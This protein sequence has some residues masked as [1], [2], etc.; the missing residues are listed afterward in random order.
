MLY[1]LTLPRTKTWQC[2][3]K[4]QGDEP[5][6]VTMHGCHPYKLGSEHPVTRLPHETC[7]CCQVSTQ[8]ILAFETHM[9]ICKHL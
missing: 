1:I 7:K 6:V 2:L 5:R 4:S 9:K 8:V 3:K